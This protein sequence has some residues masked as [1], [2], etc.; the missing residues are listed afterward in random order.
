MSSFQPLSVGQ[1][2]L[3]EFFTELTEFAAALR[4]RALETVLRP[5]PTKYR[6][7]SNL[8]SVQTGRRENPHVLL[9]LQFSA[10]VQREREDCEEN[11]RKR[12]SKEKRRKK[13]KIP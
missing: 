10:L 1:T 7:V 9:E 11:Q 13:G 2:E 3:T 5:F 4:N 8:G 12:A 6:E